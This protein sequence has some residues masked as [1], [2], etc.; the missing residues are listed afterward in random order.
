MGVKPHPCPSQFR[1]FVES[2]NATKGA[3]IADLRELN[4]LLPKP[5]PFKLPSL[6]QLDSLFSLC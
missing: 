6:R 2:K 5:L 1:A 3:L 4:S